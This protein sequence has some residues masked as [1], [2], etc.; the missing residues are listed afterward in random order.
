[1]TETVRDFPIPN[2]GGGVSLAL[3]DLIDETLCE[4]ISQVT[5]DGKFFE[6]WYEERTDLIKVTCHEE[7]MPRFKMRFVLNNYI[8]AMRG[9]NLKSITNT[10]EQYRQERFAPARQAYDTSKRFRPLFL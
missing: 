7:R 6:T 5:L 1:M 9:S 2:A 4:L 10:F 3:V 8:Y